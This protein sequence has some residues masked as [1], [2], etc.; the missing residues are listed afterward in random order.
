MG[1]FVITA[2][3]I[4]DRRQC[5]PFPALK[6]TSKQQELQVHGLIHAVLIKF[7]SRERGGRRWQRGVCAFKMD[8]NAHSCLWNHENA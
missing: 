7:F 4:P 5:C 1:T 8:P 6:R 2:V 3:D